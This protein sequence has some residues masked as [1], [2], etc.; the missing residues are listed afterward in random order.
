VDMTTGRVRRL[1]GHPR[2]YISTAG[3][4]FRTEWRS[5]RQCSRG[6]W[7]RHKEKCSMTHQSLYPPSRQT[8]SVEETMVR[9]ESLAEEEVMK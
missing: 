8:S 2:W 9:Q 5:R 1:P 3:V 4:D 6:L 7:R